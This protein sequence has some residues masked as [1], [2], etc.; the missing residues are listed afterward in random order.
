MA[1]SNVELVLAAIA[2]AI[3]AVFGA[4]FRFAIREHG[5]DPR[6]RGNLPRAEIHAG[7]TRQRALNLGRLIQAGFVA[8]GITSIFVM[9]VCAIGIVVLMI[10]A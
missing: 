2:F 5:N 3:V 1:P 9:I 7:G 4:A 8:L 6:V 10:A